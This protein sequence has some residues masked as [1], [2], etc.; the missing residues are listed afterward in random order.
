MIRRPPRSTLFPYT[1]LFRSDGLIDEPIAVTGLTLHGNK[2]SSRTHPP[3]IVFHTGNGRV[4]ALREDLGALEELLEC[5]WS[6]YKQPGLQPI[7]DLP[8]ESLCTS[9]FP[10]VPALV[11]YHGGPRD[12]RGNLSTKTH[13]DSRS[14][15]DVCTGKG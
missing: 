7:D 4:P 6:D 8:C 12:H 13:R 3:G 9:V 10:V 2:N 11:L 14:R 5:H 15:R 1:T